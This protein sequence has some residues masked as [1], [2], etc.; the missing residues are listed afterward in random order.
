[1]TVCHK[2]LTCSSLVI[3]NDMSKRKRLT[4]DSNGTTNWTKFVAKWFNFDAPE[5][6]LVL[7]YQ[8]MHGAL[9]VVWDNM[10][11]RPTCCDQWSFPRCNVNPMEEKE[12]DTNTTILYTALR[13][14]DNYI[15]RHGKQCWLDV[16][17]IFMVALVLTQ[18]FFFDPDFIV[19]EMYQFE[20]LE[21]GRIRLASMEI[22]MLEAS[23][24][25]IELNPTDILCLG[26]MFEDME[27][28]CLEKCLSVPK[29][30]RP[31]EIGVEELHEVTHSLIC[32]E[33]L[34]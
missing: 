5:D 15:K 25:I 34:D 2:Y 12:E 3:C 1:M 8:W 32:E 13:L 10:E 30:N 9:D 20:L 7:L 18:K 17:S 33:T 21:A 4:E 11:F 29:Y 28:H 31:I 16:Q 19:Y 14:T 22:P 23:D 6:D 26:A 24:Y 27:S